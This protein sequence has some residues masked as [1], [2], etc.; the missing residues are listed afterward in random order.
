MGDSE[1]EV[2]DSSTSPNQNVIAF[3]AGDSHC[4][5][6]APCTSCSWRIYEASAPAYPL[7]SWS[8]FTR[9][10]DGASPLRQ[11]NF[12]PRRCFCA[13]NPPTQPGVVFRAEYRSDGLQRLMRCPPSAIR[14]AAE[15][16]WDG[17]QAQGGP[18]RRGTT[19]R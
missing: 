4:S 8:C 10:Y 7:D 19:T 9:A 1:L 13:Q 17:F 15:W 5:A 12:C 18:R 6:C 14:F 16:L 11:F 2:L 3:V